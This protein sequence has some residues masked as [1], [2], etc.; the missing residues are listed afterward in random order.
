[1]DILQMSQEKSP[2]EIQGVFYDL[3]YY[4]HLCRQCNINVIIVAVVMEASSKWRGNEWGAHAWTNTS[5]QHL[6]EHQPEIYLFLNDF[7]V[8]HLCHTIHFLW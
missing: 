2:G 8:L 3:S 1:M 5:W 4:C 7:R 6:R